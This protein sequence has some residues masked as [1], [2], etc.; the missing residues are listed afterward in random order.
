MLSETFVFVPS[1]NHAPFIEECLRSII[2]QTLQ[3]VKLLVIDDGS[4][5]DSPAI[6]ESVLKD[7]P[8]DSELIVRENR[9]LCR[10]LNEG[11]AL[12]MGKY[13]AYIGSDDYWLP[14]FIESRSKLL[15]A[16]KS[17][18]LGYG[19]VYFVDDDGKIFDSTAE[20][21]DKWANY[22]DGY[23]GPMLLKGIAPISSSIFYRRS[24]LESVSWNEDS[25]L[26]DYEMYLRLMNL[27]EFAFDPQILSAWRQH[28]YNTSG[29]RMLM[30]EE[31][32][33]AQHRNFESLGLTPAELDKLQTQTT[34][35][36]AR[37]ELQHGKK[38]AAMLLAR[39]SWRGAE[40]VLQLGEFALRMLVPMSILE[41]SRRSRKQA[42]A[43]D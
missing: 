1:Y 31:V 42:L 16:R 5:D 21:A 8:F 20:H 38:A 40:S 39:K 4:K 24:A 10:T 11:L 7:C 29:D 18:V 32:L 13:F 6:I 27:G 25:R 22:P 37:M 30:L 26:E 36:Y 34:F 43:R 28:G 3:P 12:S 14:A 41:Y 35:Q 23:A 19:H 33:N 15:E 9:G 17:A 2:E